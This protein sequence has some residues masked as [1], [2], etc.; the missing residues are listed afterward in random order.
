MEQDSWMG[1][2]LSHHFAVKG[3]RVN[4]VPAASQQ[5]AAKPG[6]PPNSRGRS[7]VSPSV[8]SVLKVQKHAI[9]QTKIHIKLIWL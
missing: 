2:R 6:S 4:C 1:V 5:T 8:P 9:K 3:Q 7:G